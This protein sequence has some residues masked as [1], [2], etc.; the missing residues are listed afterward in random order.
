MTDG[1]ETY[2]TLKK[3]FIKSAKK[4]ILAVDHTKFDKISFVRLGE[5]EDI[6]IVVTD[7]EPIDKW[8]RLFEE[9]GIEVYY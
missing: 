1:R 9:K 7:I 4:V 3:A 5:L 6:D 8:K 2:A